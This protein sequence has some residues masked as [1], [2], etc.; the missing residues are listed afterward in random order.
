MLASNV[1]FKVLLMLVYFIFVPLD[2]CWTLVSL[3]LLLYLM[4]I[5]RVNPAALNIAIHLIVSMV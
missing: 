4:V 3:I 1:V 2:M 5:S